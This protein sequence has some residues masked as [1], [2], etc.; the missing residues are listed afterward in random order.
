MALTI[1]ADP[2][3]FL[4]KDG[5]VTSAYGIVP[6]TKEKPF[7]I[8]NGAV[9]VD[10]IAAEFN[11]A[12]AETAEE[13]VHNVN[14]MMGELRKMIPKDHEISIESVV[15]LDKHMMA[16][17]KPEE[18]ALGCDPD[19]NAYTMDIQQDGGMRN[20]FTPMRTG[21]GHVHVGW[22]KDQDIYENIHFLS[23]VDVVRQMDAL[24]G[25]PSV[26]LDTKSIR[27]EMYGQTG[28]FRP[29]PYG[30]EYRVLSNFWL[31]KPEYTEFVFSQT[32]K[33]FDLLVDKGENFYR[34]YGIALPNIVSYWDIKSAI[35]IIRNDS[36]FIDKKDKELFKD[37]L[38][39][40]LVKEVY[41]SDP[42]YWTTT[43][44]TFIGQ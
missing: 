19:F 40:L 39:Y 35:D 9:Q 26:L 22:T 1:G 29:K 14:D 31:K 13:F 12:P 2:E 4:V 20:A 23:C 41:N 7:P 17:L 34:K 6:G 42:V 15:S 27:S 10:G 8:G 32:K 24:V 11:I 16:T 36:K 44:A 43:D 25:V 37:R 5:R 38:D 28:T 33:A 3:V 21:G 18:F 30:V